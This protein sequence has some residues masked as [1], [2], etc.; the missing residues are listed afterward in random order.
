MSIQQKDMGDVG[1][2]PQV[3]KTDNHLMRRIL[4]A[5]VIGGEIALFISMLFPIWRISYGGG[6]TVLEP[7]WFT[8]QEALSSGSPNQLIGSLGEIVMTALMVFAMGSV[9][10]VLCWLAL[11]HRANAL[12]S[13]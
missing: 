12:N 3:I 1:H 6:M 13:L 4:T 9:L 7:L 5:C 11:K 10:G 8:A 2:R